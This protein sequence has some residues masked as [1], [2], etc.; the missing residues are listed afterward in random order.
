MIDS[1]RPSKLEP[2]FAMTNRIPTD[3]TASTMTSDPGRTTVR[4][5]IEGGKAPPAS[6]ASCRSVGAAREPPKA[7]PP[8]A[9]WPPAVG[10]AADVE[11]CA[12]REIPL[13]AAVAPAA[14]AAA[15]FKKPRRS[16]DAFFDFAIPSSDEV[17]KRHPRVADAA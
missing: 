3:L 16:S 8:P 12:S 6:L 15:L 11:G 2:G 14:P 10:S 7:P 17:S 9:L 4:G 5:G 13:T 1:W